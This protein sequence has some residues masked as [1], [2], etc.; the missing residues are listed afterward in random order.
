MDEKV[1]APCRVGGRKRGQKREAVLEGGGKKRDSMD[2]FNVTRM[3][4]IHPA[5]K[6][7]SID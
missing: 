3:T 6:G 7:I 5:F 4:G 1:P 2:A